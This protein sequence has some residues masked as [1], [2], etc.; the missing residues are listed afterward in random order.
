[1]CA[2]IRTYMH[3]Y[4][5]T[6]MH[7]YTHTCMHTPIHVH[8]V[9]TPNCICTGITHACI[10]TSMYTHTTHMYTC[11]YMYAIIH[12]THIHLQIYMYYVDMDI[13]IRPCNHM[14][15]Y[16]QHVVL[17]L[18]PRG[19]MRDVSSIDTC[20][21]CRYC[22]ESP[23]RHKRSCNTAPVRTQAPCLKIEVLYW[24]SRN[25]KQPLTHR[26][27][28]AI[29]G[30]DSEIMKCTASVSIAGIRKPNRSFFVIHSSGSMSN[31]FAA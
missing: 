13:Y 30:G 25:P 24:E 23:A 16:R 9:Y 15:L 21:A 19:M 10:T 6:Y 28:V 12:Y 11:T 20:C 14:H 31:L 7:A 22:P 5:Q 27:V 17:D 4:I 1:M 29:A 3:T 2:R 8:M 26:H 18:V